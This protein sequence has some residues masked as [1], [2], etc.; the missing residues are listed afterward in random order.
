MFPGSDSH[1]I[2]GILAIKP[3][4][5]F[6]TGGCPNVPRLGELEITGINTIYIILIRLRDC[7]WALEGVINQIL[8]QLALFQ[9]LPQVRVF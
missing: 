7:S 3:I 2:I 4:L 6:L 9:N 5:G 1:K 8:I